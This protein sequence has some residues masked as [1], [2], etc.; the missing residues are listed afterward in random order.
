VLN[1][2]ALQNEIQ[3]GVHSE[4]KKKRLQIMLD[5]LKDLASDKAIEVAKLLKSFE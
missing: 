5:D 4:E 2:F 1:Y 3:N